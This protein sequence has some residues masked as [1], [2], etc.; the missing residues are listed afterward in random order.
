M[1]PDGTREDE[2][3]GSD[4]VTATDK[5]NAQRDAAR[6]LRNRSLKARW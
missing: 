1:R 6:I 3:R 2:N 5:L 4:A